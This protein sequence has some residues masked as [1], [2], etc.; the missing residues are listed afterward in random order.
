MLP[1]QTERHKPLHTKCFN[2]KREM[3]F[4]WDAQGPTREA[5]EDGWGLNEIQGLRF[6]A[7]YCRVSLAMR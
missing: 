4:P 1:V 3:R 7:L 2:A 5:E 6:K